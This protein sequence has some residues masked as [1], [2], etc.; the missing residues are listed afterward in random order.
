MI[1][2]CGEDG[3][4]EEVLERITHNAKGAATDVHTYFGWGALSA[5]TSRLRVIVDGTYG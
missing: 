4:R 2:V 1:S 3:A 5:A